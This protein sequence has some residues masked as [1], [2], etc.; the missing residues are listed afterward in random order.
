MTEQQLIQAIFDKANKFATMTGLHSANVAYV[1]DKYKNLCMSQSWNVINGKLILLNTITVFFKPF[2]LIFVNYMENPS[3]EMRNIPVASEST[4][5]RTFIKIGRVRL[6][7]ADIV[8]YNTQGTEELYIT[9]R[10]SK[11]NK[12]IR[13]TPDVIKQAIIDLDKYFNIQTIL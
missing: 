9:L 2:D 11:D 7:V 10:Y 12:C 8:S 4:K 6:D 3:D 5:L 13:E 1:P